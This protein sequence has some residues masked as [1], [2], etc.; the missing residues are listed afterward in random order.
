MNILLINHYAGS[1]QHGMEYRPFYLSREWQRMGHRVQIVAASWSHL[2]RQS[3]QLNGSATEAD[4]EGVPFLWLKTPKYNGNGTRRVFN[5]LWFVGQLYRNANRF[6]NGSKPDVV[7]ASSTYPLDNLPARFIARRC[8]AKLVY[9]VHDLWPLSP[10][11]LG[12]MSPAHPFILMMQWA[13]NAAY[14]GADRVVSVLPNARPHMEAHGMT[15]EKFAFVPNGI[16]VADWQTAGD[17]DTLPEL[18]NRVLSDLRKSGKFV[19]GYAGGH[20]VSNALDVLL[21]SARLLRAERL[22]FV[23]VG[24][25]AEKEALQKKA[26]FLP[27]AN[28]TFL[29]PIPRTAVPALLRLM[30]GVY[31]GWQNKPI[32]RF[33]VSPNKLLDYMMAGKPVVHST[34]ASNDLVA[35]SHCGFTVEPENAQEIANSIRRL[36]R[37][38]PAERESMGQRGREYVV[39]HH[40]YK[41]LAERYL[42]LLRQ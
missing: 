4:V 22:A 23:L 36:M 19:L 24:S 30:D 11:Q 34:N 21:E 9:E 37:L 13:E 20:A 10:V 40:D 8:G 16:A 12:G 18:H 26:Q 2:R 33:G 6:S 25:G 27:L 28:V 15:A 7:I 29:P 35:E 42:E 3:P 32:Y 31:L 41:V 14:R 17:G 38:S 5:M 1:R 39:K